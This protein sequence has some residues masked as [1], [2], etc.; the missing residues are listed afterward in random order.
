MIKKELIA[1]I[2]TLEEGEF[3][4]VNAIDGE[5]GHFLLTLGQARIVINGAELVEAM[6]SIDYY[7]TLFKQEALAKE[8]RAKSPPKAV[9]VTP[10]PKK[11]KRVH[12][13]EEGTIVLDP[14][15]R[16]GLTDSELALERQT[17]HMQGD[18]IVITEKK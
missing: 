2:S 11:G 17:K 13:E 9:V 12:T 7:G 15:F 3:T 14:V 1:F 5:P 16:S 6:T 18:T 4:K 10:P 8:Q